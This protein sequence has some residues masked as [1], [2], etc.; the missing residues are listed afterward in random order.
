MA[1]QPNARRN[2][3]KARGQKA[4]EERAAVAAQMKAEK[5]GQPQ[6]RG[7]TKEQQAQ[8]G[9]AVVDLSGNAVWQAYEERKQARLAQL[10]A[11]GAEWR[12]AEALEKQ[13]VIPTHEQCQDCIE[14]VE[15]GH[16][17]LEAAESLGYSYYAINKAIRKSKELS[18]R[19]NDA[20]EMY[21]HERVR[22]VSAIIAN[23]PDPAR[24]RILADLIK[25]E[26]SKVLPKFYGDK[27]DVA[28]TDKVSFSF[29]L[30]PSS[31]KK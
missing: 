17:L 26:V 14:L 8:T 18:A 29:G 24:A 30:A 3:G 21:A 11:E 7:A 23:E 27:L 6:K 4:A 1:G 28:V 20:K 12:R 19:L 13:G 2:A 15:S 10:Q 31:S 9:T 25:W 22:R 5:A 16:N